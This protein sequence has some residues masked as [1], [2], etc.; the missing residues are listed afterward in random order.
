M[1]YTSILESL[2]D[3]VAKG[4][5]VPEIVS[6]IDKEDK[7][8][9][10]CEVL[11]FKREIPSTDF[12]YAKLYKDILAFHNSYGGFIIMGINETKKDREFEIV[13]IEDLKLDYA[14]IRDNLKKYTEQEIRF[15]IHDYDFNNK[16]IE[17]IWI[18]KRMSGEKPVVFVKNG[19]EDEDKK[20]IF[21]KSEITFRKSDCNVTAIQPDDYDFLYSQRM[22]PTLSKTNEVLVFTDPLENNLPDR[23]IVCSKFIGR[24]SDVSQLW[25]WLSDDFSRVK[26]IAGEG[27]LGKTSLAY[28]FAELVSSRHVKPFDKVI[29]LSAKQKQFVPQRDNYL[30]SLQVDY[31][32]ANSLFQSICLELGCNQEDFLDL[33]TRELSK[34]AM[35]VCDMIP[36]FIVIDDVDSLIP[37]EQRR[38]LEFGLMA[39]SKSKILL[40]TRVNFTYS[41][42]TFIKLNGF[43]INEYH[44]YV[45][46]MRNKYHLAPLPE[47][48]IKSLH[49]TTSGSPLFTDSL[50]RLELRGNNIDQAINAWREQKGQEVR[51]AALQ[52]EI[53]QLSTHARR[54]I[55]IISNLQNCSLTEL[56]QLLDYSEQTLSDSLVELS[57]LFLINAPIVGS[58]V[59]YTVDRNT[60]RLV[61]E[62][63]ESLQI[64]HSALLIKIKNRKSDAISLGLNARNKIIGLAINEAIAKLKNNDSEGAL[65]TVVAAAK[66]LTRP[67]ADLLL[68][69]GRCSLKLREPKLEEAM[70]AFNDAY[71]L[72]LRKA[73]LFKLWYETECA[74]SAYDSAIEVAK[75]AIAENNDLAYWNE[76][77]A[78]VH[79]LKA[80]RSNSQI[81][82]DAVIRELNLAIVAFKEARKSN[83]NGHE[84]NRIDR[85]IES[86]IDLQIRLKNMSM[87]PKF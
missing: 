28:H 48:K 37:D 35:Q 58:D 3:S 32:D 45:T 44:D 10:E 70:K 71:N 34:L 33:D 84:K 47:Q 29:W 5:L 83:D 23:S 86:A 22:A 76:R 16:K 41:E 39:R 52:R 81:S 43:P 73:L 60:G 87:K 54:V 1:S 17:T 46:V 11:D 20:C 66:R 9:R 77:M 38:V 67:N 53:N 36:S 8:L 42:D 7:S 75:K 69:I 4:G 27:G 30:D 79:I 61:I 80:R 62:I 55:F 50:L 49:D 21:K 56:K 12:D 15:V 19:P 25:N 24:N 59:R 2:F 31:A 57:N 63:A 65:E 72:G 51:K 6:L 74:R 18:S 40:T 68:A 85:L 82:N 78:G 26:L 14:K 64:D 13:G